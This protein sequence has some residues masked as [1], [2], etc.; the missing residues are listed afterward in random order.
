[1]T[2]LPYHKL[3]YSL[4]IGQIDSNHWIKFVTLV[5]KQQQEICSIRIDQPSPQQYWCRNC[6]VVQC[7]V[8]CHNVC[9]GLPCVLLV[10]VSRDHSTGPGA[11][12]DDSCLITVTV[13]IPSTDLNPLFTLLYCFILIY[14]YKHTVCTA[15][16]NVLAPKWLFVFYT[17]LERKRSGG[18][19]R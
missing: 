15:S 19:N 14:A 17:Q 5:Y 1:M 12:T 9:A 4:T 3:P 11:T 10:D 16:A 6:T 7:V 2:Y 18:G 8:F 13:P